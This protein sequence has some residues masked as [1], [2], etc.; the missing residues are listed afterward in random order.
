MDN[1]ELLVIITNNYEE[2][3]HFISEGSEYN[4]K[5]GDVL[6]TTNRDLVSKT[7]ETYLGSISEESVKMLTDEVNADGIVTTVPVLVTGGGN[8]KLF[9]VGEY[10]LIYEREHTKE[11]AFEVDA[12]TTIYVDLDLLEGKYVFV[13][14]SLPDVSLEEQFKEV[15]DRIVESPITLLYEELKEL[16][17]LYFVFQYESRG[18]RNI[19]YSLQS[20][21][22]LINFKVRVGWNCIKGYETV[23]DIVSDASYVNTETGESYV[24]YPTGM[25]GFPYLVGERVVYDKELAEDCNASDLARSKVSTGTIISIDPKDKHGLVL[26]VRPDDWKPTEANRGILIGHVPL[27]IVMPDN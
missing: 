2:E 20:D 26:E 12:M 1:K 27:D 19:L 13:K 14:D 6:P 24:G 18:R 8:A 22:E 7:L 15:M 21:A 9:E 4:L 5:P 25:N 16:G 3:T 11:V 23:G 10:S 17:E